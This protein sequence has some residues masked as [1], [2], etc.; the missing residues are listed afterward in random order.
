VAA[1]TE[2]ADVDAARA[3]REVDDLGE[4]RWPLGQL[5]AR[6]RAVLVLR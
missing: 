1:G 3:L 5:P 2:A 4:F 6:Q